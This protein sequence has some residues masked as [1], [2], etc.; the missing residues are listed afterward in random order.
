MNYLEHNYSAFPVLSLFITGIA[1]YFL[2]RLLRFI[3]P[4]IA[5]HRKAREWI[6]QYFSLFELFIWVVFTLWFLP[7][8]MHRNLYAGYSLAFI[9]MAIFIW[10]SLYGLRNLIAGFIFRSNNGLKI[11]EHI[12]I[13]EYKGSIV[14]MAYRSIILDSANGDLISLPYS[15]IVNQALIKIS[16]TELRHSHSFNLETAKAKN[17][18]KLTNEIISKALM[19]PRYSLTESPKVELVQE[20]D[21]KMLFSVK[22]FAIENKYLSIIEEYLKL[23]FENKKA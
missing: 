22:I 13:G 3:I 14:K 15:K 8:L 20:L 23:E 1:V 2:L 4:Y 16:S 18:Q 11:G 10:V 6:H 19:H 9:L 21:D 12:Q 5:K 7:Y 17:I